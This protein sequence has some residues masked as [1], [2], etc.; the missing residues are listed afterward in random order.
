LFAQYFVFFEEVNTAIVKKK[1]LPEAT[2][3]DHQ[4]HQQQQQSEAT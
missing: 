2:L 3:S 1:L 4:I